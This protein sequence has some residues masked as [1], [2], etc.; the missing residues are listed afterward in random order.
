LS[1]PLLPSPFHARLTSHYVP[2]LS[3]P[4]HLLCCPPKYPSPF[5]TPSTVIKTGVLS[6][7]S[8]GCLLQEASSDFCQAQ[9]CHLQPP[10]FPHLS[11]TS[12]CS[13][14]GNDSPW[15]RDHISRAIF[16]GGTRRRSQQGRRRLRYG[17]RGTVI[18]T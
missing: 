1:P 7:D 6:L 15:D 2:C 17:Q 3:K 16:R 12:P 8:D 13:S 9:V 5:P 4:L 14:A 10:N 11:P 18:P